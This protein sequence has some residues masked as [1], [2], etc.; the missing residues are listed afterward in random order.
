MRQFS[1]PH[2]G[3]VLA[4][5]ASFAVAASAARAEVLLYEATL[6]P[7]NIIPPSKSPGG[8]MA[9][10]TYDTATKLFTWTVTYSMLT[11]MATAAHIHGP[12]DEEKDA[13]VVIPFSSA[14]TPIT[15]SRTLTDAQAADM[16]A[17]KWYVNVHTAANPG[18][19]IRGMIE[20]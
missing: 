19:E 4:A 7:E 9:N 6:E 20:K 18:G 15:G 11:G 10:F 2:L 1:H 3:I 12:A 5:V 17:G 16:M 13:G 14:A 8:G